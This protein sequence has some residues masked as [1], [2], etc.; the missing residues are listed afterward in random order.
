MKPHSRGS[1]RLTSTEPQ[2]PP[3]I[4]HGALSDSGGDDLATLAD[5][6]E[7]AREI[8]ACD[9]LFRRG[10]RELA[11]DGVSDDSLASHVRSTL[12]CYF[13]PVGTCRIGAAGDPLAVVDGEGA[14]YGCPGLYVADASIMPTIPRA[15]TH[16]TTL[17]VA[18]R[19]AELLG[20]SAVRP[21]E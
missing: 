15:N 21:G 1:L 19:I 18:E 5:G 8:A 9:P 20:R 2:T 12:G 14:V 7:R 4:D 3:R 10:V 13:H 16:L 17:A 11:P 6:I